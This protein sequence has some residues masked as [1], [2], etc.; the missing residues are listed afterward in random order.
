MTRLR[1]L[2]V[3]TAVTAALLALATAPPVLGA[4]TTRLPSIEQVGAT[5]AAAPSTP[6]WTVELDRSQVTSSIGKH[7]TF[8]ST[9]HNETGAPRP[10][11]IAY[12]N[13][14]SMQSDVYVDPEDWSSA[15]TK[16]LG[17][18][19]PGATTRLTWTVQAVNSGR[20]K[21]FVVVTSAA[22]GDEVVSSPAL[23]V[24]IAD[25]RRL[26]PSGILPVVLVVPATVALC[27]AWSRRRRRRLR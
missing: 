12:L 9:L 20:F 17:V 2:L 26:N 24:T 10:G 7:F 3:T 23:P 1:C 4:V 8:V 22:G 27:L 18:V 19:G 25:Q 11:T 15:R 13:V 6:T 5:A 21:I 16:F 14:V